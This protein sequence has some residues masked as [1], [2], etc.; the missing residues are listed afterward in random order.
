M[1]VCQVLLRKTKS[2][3]NRVA[4]ISNPTSLFCLVSFLKLGI[5]HFITLS[6]NGNY[7]LLKIL[8]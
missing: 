3:I 4:E 7:L 8:K 5:L 6:Y 2:D 1:K